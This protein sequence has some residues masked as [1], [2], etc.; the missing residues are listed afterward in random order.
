MLKFTL[1]M[2]SVQEF[3]PPTDK[4][5]ALLSY[6]FI[7]PEGNFITDGEEL[8][9]LPGRHTEYIEAA[10]IRLVSKGLP[11]MNQRIPVVGYGANA[12]PV[13]FAEK[14]AAFAT[15]ASNE[16]L[17]V[18]PFEGVE[19]EGSVVWHGKQGQSGGIFAELYNGPLLPMG[20]TTPC[21]VS[22]LTPEQLAVMHTTE[23]ITY[24]LTEVLA[25]AGEDKE[26][27]AAYAYTAGISSLLI[28]DGEPVAVKRPG[29]STAS[30][31]TAPEALTYILDTV[32]GSE[33][34]DLPKAT[35][36]QELVAE[37]TGKPNLTANKRAQ[38]AVEAALQAKGAS[39]LY[40]YSTAQESRIGRADF[41]FVKGYHELHLLE[42][43]VEP[44]REV[45]DE[46]AAANIQ[47][48]VDL[49]DTIRQAVRTKDPAHKVRIRA[50]NELAELVDSSK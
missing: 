12:N 2:T 39:Q 19:V 4:H 35:T 30:G 43:V 31:M 36:P 25:F 49:E 22:W 46:T 13:R 26:P 18:T 5:E 29:E 14:M 27:I 47:P 15:E 38:A 10:E 23:G 41:N 37:M 24:Q 42:E 44:I 7:M 34:A 50:H 45:V 16:L 40:A 3:S 33:S 28:K 48:G 17:Q 8:T 6:P 1:A 11:G 20:A 32:A 9:E 21:K